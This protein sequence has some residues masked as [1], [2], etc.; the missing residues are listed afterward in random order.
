MILFTSLKREFQQHYLEDTS[1]LYR[2]DQL[3]KEM[4]V[5]ERHLQKKLLASVKTNA[6]AEGS[7]GTVAAATGLA[8][9]KMKK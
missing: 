6:A 9:E 1:R 2:D 3:C 8:G 5:A 7:Q 4:N